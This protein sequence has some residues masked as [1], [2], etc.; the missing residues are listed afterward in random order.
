MIIAIWTFVLVINLLFCVIKKQ[1]SIVAFVSVVAIILITGGNNMNADYPGYYYYYNSQIYPSSMEIGYRLFAR[2][3]Y[4]AG[5]SYQCSV[6]I[7]LAFTSLLVAFVV[8]RYKANSHVV[9]ALYMSTMLFLDAV[10]IRQA[11]AYAFY[12]LFVMFL[13]EN[14]R[15]LGT[16]CLVVAFLFQRTAIVF[17]PLIWLDPEKRISKRAIKIIVSIIAA[18]CV[19]VFINGNS[20]KFLIPLLKHFVSADK[21]TYFET[22]T[23]FGFLKYFAFQFGCMFMAK[24][25]KLSL[26]D[27]VLD[28]KYS[29]FA[30]YMFM[31][32][33]YACFALPMVMINNNFSRFF[34]Y[35]MI[36]VFLCISFIYK[37]RNK[38]NWPI[39][40]SSDMF[41][42][43]PVF[44][45]MTFVYVLIYQL[46]IQIY[47]VTRDV[48]TYNIM[49]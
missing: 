48:F 47:S 18:S 27:L 12:A 23:H 43:G 34:K 26:S 1:S 35:S 31:S 17:L 37:E 20:L 5:F 4:S 7:I 25:C 32:V 19:I 49:L 6:I 28:D 24:T 21:L 45:A 30:D 42:S 11:L 13:A 44:A 46:T 14:K 9:I 22:S 16:V 40:V 29:H 10:Q 8:I 33:M 41:I 39:R 36:P 15:V 38:W 2:L 3:F